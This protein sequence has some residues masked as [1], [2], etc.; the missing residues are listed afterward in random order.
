[1]KYELNVRQVI[2]C[3]HTVVINA[4]EG[5]DI[6]NILDKAQKHANFLDDITSNLERLGCEI[7]DTYEDDGDTDEIEIDDY[8]EVKGEE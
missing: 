3:N 7:V 1:M 4:P 5:K 6:E 8:N 2:V